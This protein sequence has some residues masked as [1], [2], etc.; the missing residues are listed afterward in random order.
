MFLKKLVFLLL[1]MCF[2]AFSATHYIRDG[3]SG[4]GTAWDNALDDLPSTLTRGDVY[5]MADGTY[6]G[7]TFNDDA[8]G[9]DLIT[10][11]KATAGDHGTETGWVST[12][13]D[14]TASFSGQLRFDD[15]YYTIDGQT[16]TTETSGYGFY[17]D[18]T[19]GGRGIFFNTDLADNIIIRYVEIEGR[20]DDGAGSPAN[21]GVYTVRDAS[22]NTFQYMYIHDMG[23]TM[24]LGRNADDWIIE[25]CYLDTNESVA[26]QH[27]EAISA[28]SG[29]DRWIIR[30]N[31][32]VDIEGTGIIVFAGDGWE[33]YGNV[34]WDAGGGGTLGNGSF[35]TWTGYTVTNAK[36]YNNTFVDLNGAGGLGFQSGNIGNNN[37]AYNNLWYNCSSVTHSGLDTV[38]YNWY[39]SVSPEQDEPNVQN[40]SSDPFDDYAN[41]DFHISAE[42]DDGL[43]L[44]SPY[45]TDLDGVVRGN[46]GVWDRGAYEH[47]AGSPPAT[48]TPAPTHTPTFTPTPGPTPTP[49]PTNTPVGLALTL[50]AHWEMT[51]DLT[52]S[53]NSHDGTQNNGTITYTTGAIGQAAVFDGNAYIT[54]PAAADLNALNNEFSISFWIKIDSAFNSAD[55]IIY[56]GGLGETGWYSRGAT[57]GRAIFKTFDGTDERY[58]GTMDAV[59]PISTGSW[60]HIAFVVNNREALYCWFNTLAQNIE[61]GDPFSDVGDI[62]NSLELKIGAN[63]SG[64]ERFTGQLDDVRI[65]SG[66]FSNDDVVTLF[67]LGN[68]ST[69]GRRPSLDGGF[70]DPGKGGFD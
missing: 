58:D 59:S 51:N 31:K 46:I 5:Y 21:D 53:A 18:R 7:Y 11:K 38:D 30:Y 6:S 35:C 28:F 12:Y 26:A 25:Y 65:Y 4:D 42:T 23:R 52:D 47:V 54:V 13:G 14:G 33:L 15:P 45:N 17:V 24:F 19:S 40:E 66:K 22:N 3:G 49:T 39:A 34:T 2:P 63:G 56:K 32:W 69:G 10:I 16:R 67:N 41:D 36:I 61:W 68:V 55:Y 20:G 9:T 8:S 70:R 37:V 57:D 1:F 48:N 50:L 43:T 62:S 27:S 60:H 29:T 64:T 44:M